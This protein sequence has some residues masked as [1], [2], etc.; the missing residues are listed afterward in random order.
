MSLHG[1][2]LATVTHTP[3]APAGAP[4]RATHAE[5]VEQPGCGYT[6]ESPAGAHGKN[7]AG[8]VVGQPPPALAHELR[9]DHL[10][11]THEHDVPQ[12]AA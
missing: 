9:H 6:H 11:A 12:P 3:S 7:R 5:V 8:R 2:G 1:S 10:F 4:S